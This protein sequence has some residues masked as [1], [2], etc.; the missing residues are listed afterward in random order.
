MVM[1]SL[2]SPAD[3]QLQQLCTQLR[4]QR[5]QARIDVGMV[6]GEP[7]VRLQVC[8]ESRPDLSVEVLAPGPPTPR[9]PHWDAVRVL[10][11]ARHV[12]RGPD[13]GCALDE[14]GRFVQALLSLGV[15]QLAQL[16]VDL[17]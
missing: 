9:T 1:T 10:G 7:D 4:E 5:L 2:H 15:A 16:Y 3:D 17:G 13:S 12:W 11:D 14:V 8:R 6:A